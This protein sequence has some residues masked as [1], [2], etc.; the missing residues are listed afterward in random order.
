LECEIAKEMLDLERENSRQ[1]QCYAHVSRARLLAG[2]PSQTVNTLGL[3]TT[4]TPQEA[5]PPQL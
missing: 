2:R 3:S 4:L 5:S 1:D